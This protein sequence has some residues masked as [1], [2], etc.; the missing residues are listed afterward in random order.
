[1]SDSSCLRWPG[2]SCS[3]ARRS[4]VS[5]R[6]VSRSTAFRSCGLG[7][8]LFARA[9]RTSACGRCSDPRPDRG[10]ARAPNGATRHLHRR[11]SDPLALP[12]GRHRHRRATWEAQQDDRPAELKEH[13]RETSR[14]GDL[15]SLGPGL[16]PQ[17]SLP[18]HALCGDQPRDRVELADVAPA[19]AAQ[20]RAEGGGAL[21]LKS[22]DPG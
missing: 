9:S 1:M 5:P 20:E 2:T 16:A 6:L 19:E 13:R 17:E 15:E 11:R 14:R 3:R 7:S 8:A 21:T 22:V 12:G 4:S 10:A 18:T